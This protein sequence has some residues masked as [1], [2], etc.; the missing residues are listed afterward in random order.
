MTPEQQ[1][2][3]VGGGVIGLLLLCDGV[4]FML[5]MTTLPCTRWVGRTLVRATRSVVGG[6]VITVGTTIRGK[7][8]KKKGPRRRRS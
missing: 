6:A 5:G 4:A 3:Y 7:K 2:W 8:P 1:L